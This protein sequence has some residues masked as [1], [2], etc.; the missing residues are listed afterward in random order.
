[1]ENQEKTVKEEASTHKVIKGRTISKYSLSTFIGV[2]GFATVCI[3][4]PNSNSMFTNGI[5][6]N[7]GMIDL[8]YTIYMIYE[9]Y[10]D[11]KDKKKLDELDEDEPL[12]RA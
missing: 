5:L 8:L 1:M 10:G 6:V 11:R 9:A 4:V 3:A 12:K 2:L 7:I